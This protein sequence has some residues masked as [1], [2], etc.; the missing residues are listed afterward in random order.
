MS[1]AGRLDP[2]SRAMAGWFLAR[3][4][5]VAALALLPCVATGRPLREGMGLAVFACALGGTVSMLFAALRQEPMG[6]GSL[7]GWDESLAFIA[8]S[9]LAHAAMAMQG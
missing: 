7:N 2:L 3:L 1:P 4:G 8:A 6:R 9:R 5:F